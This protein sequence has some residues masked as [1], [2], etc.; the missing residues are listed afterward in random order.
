[1]KPRQQPGGKLQRHPAAAARTLDAGR[2]AI[3]APDVNLVDP[4]ER[5]ARPAR[6]R[7]R[8]VEDHEQV[9]SRLQH[10]APSLAQTVFDRLG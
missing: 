10:R 4:V 1:V 3:A 8:S 7:L 6:E 5:V 2:P 9:R